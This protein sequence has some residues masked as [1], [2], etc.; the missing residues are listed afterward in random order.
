MH[1]ELTHLTFLALPCRLEDGAGS[2]G[3]NGP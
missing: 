1:P 3:I 2:P